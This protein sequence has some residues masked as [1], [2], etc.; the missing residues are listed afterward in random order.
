MANILNDL[1][2]AAEENL[3]HYIEL[4]DENAIRAGRG[5]VESLKADIAA[6]SN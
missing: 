6:L 1:L 4:G 2:A 5:M 3:A